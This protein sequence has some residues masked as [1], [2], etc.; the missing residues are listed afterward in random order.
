VY[1]A[2]RRNLIL[3]LIGLQEDVIGRLLEKHDRA[4]VSF[5]DLGAG[6]LSELVLASHPRANGVLVD[7][8]EHM[9]ARAKL[10]LS[11]WAGRFRLL[12]ADLAAPDWRAG[13]PAGR[14]D[15]VISG[16][17]IHH[18]CSSRKQELFK[19]LFA[20]LEPGG[21]FINMDYVA[22]VGPLRR[23]FDKLMHAN[24]VRADRDSGSSRAGA[25]IELDDG[26]DQPDPLEHQL[27]WLRAAGFE[28]VEV[29]FKWAEAAV[30]GGVRA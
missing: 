27:R 26:E 28:Q 2:D 21:I 8:S 22:I 5:L 18:L 12:H 13:L 3:P 6:A 1:F 29:H 10:E 4:I 15:A 30:F 11:P 9:L 23:S 7:F 16:L 20:L 17:A 24:A 25:G 19:E 14:Y